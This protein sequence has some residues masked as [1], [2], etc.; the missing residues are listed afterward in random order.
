MAAGNAAVKHRKGESI[1]ADLA[2]PIN[3]D[4]E[5]QLELL[6]RENGNQ[7]V[8]DAL[9]PL[10]SKCAFKDWLCV[11]NAVERLARKAKERRSRT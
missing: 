10:I 9:T 1:G 11:A 8:I 3:S 7:K 6:V 5:R 2:A 4:I